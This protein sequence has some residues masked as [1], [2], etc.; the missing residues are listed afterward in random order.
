MDTIE[1]IFT[2]Y[3][4]SVLGGIAILII[5][6]IVANA[7]QRSIKTLMTKRETVDPL[8]AGFV[9]SL[10]KY[11]ILAFTVVA[12][13]NQFGI[14]TAS[15][16]AVLGA[17]GLAI[18]LALQGTL[19]HLAAGVMIMVFRPF[20]QGNYIEAAGTAGTV[21]SVTLFTTEL[22]TPDNVQIIVPNGK[23][24]GDIVKNY[25]HHETRRVDFA[26]GIGY[27]DSID[28][29]IKTVQGV[30]DR[31]ARAHKDPA[32]Q[33]VVG[34]LADSSVNL[35][36]RVWCASADYWGVKFDL[37]KA[38]KEALDKAKISI[39][40]PQTDVHLHQVAG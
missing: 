33:I 35:T 38:F 26:I 31:E 7:V 14:Q 16:I 19:S 6:W 8:L 40:F 13:L 32:P 2:T 25:S 12:V 9:S 34:E 15:M 37:T 21:K 11:L 24:W 22:A 30:I 23:V 27:G 5:G 39:P 36:I 10:V 29:A 3:G 18:G 17:A 4:L 20:K 28:K 1:R